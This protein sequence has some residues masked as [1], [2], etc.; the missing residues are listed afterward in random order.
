M[1]ENKLLYNSATKIDQDR[2]ALLRLVAETASFLY[3]SKKPIR[4]GFCAGAGALRY[5]IEIAS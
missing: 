5:L 4:C 3:E 2:E 1:S